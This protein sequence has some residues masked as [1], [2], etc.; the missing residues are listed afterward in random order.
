MAAQ[1]QA[2]IAASSTTGKAARADPK[3]PVEG[4]M[5]FS[6]GPQFGLKFGAS[7]SHLHFTDPAKRDFGAASQDR[8]HK[9][10]FFGSKHIDKYVPKVSPAPRTSLYESKLPLWAGSEAPKQPVDIG[11]Y[12]T[13]SK[14]SWG[15]GC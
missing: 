9:T 1:E 10:F 4:S 5:L 8:V 2:Q 3:Q 11:M 12:A 7:M 6:H 14:I 13:M 15:Q